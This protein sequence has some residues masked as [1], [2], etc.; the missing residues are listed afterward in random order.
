LNSHFVSIKVDREERPDVDRVYMA[1]VQVTTGSGG[2]P[3]SVWLTPELQPFYGGT[4]YPPHSQY[5]RPGFGDVLKE[6]ARAWRDERPQ[7]VESAQRLSARLH[8]MARPDAAIG[9]ASMPGAD[10]LT[11]TTRQF[12]SSF[13][14]RR[15]GFGDAP[16]FP[17]PSEL[18]F[19]LREHVRA[20]DDEA[21]EMALV[22]LRAMALGGMRDHIGGGFHRYSVD[23][24]WR[25]PHFEKMLYDQAQLVLAY[26]E[27]AQASQDPFFA[28]IAE[29]TLQYVSRDMTEQ[30]GGFFS[31]EDA[32][33]VP[34][35]HAADSQARKTEGAFYIWSLGEV[36]ALLG[37][38]SPTFELRYGLLPD[39]NAPFD[40]QQE[41]TGKNLLHTARGIAD[42][43]E[44]VKRQPEHVAEALTRARV[45][46]FKARER[47]PRPHLDDKVLTGWNGLMMAAF[48]RAAR[49]LS[50]SNLLGQALADDPGARHLA[51]ARRAALFL[52]DA[53]WDAGRQRLLRRYRRGDAAIDA[54]AEDYAFLIFGLLEL[55]QA[56]GDARWLEWAIALQRVQDELF[57]DREGGWYSTTGTD[58]SVL[59]RMKEEYD[60]AE[61]SASGVG[62][63]NLLTFAQLTG[64][65]SYSERAREV[66][67]AF[68]VRLQSL[69]RALP[70]MAA[71]L[72]AAHAS[73]EQIIVVG[74]A[75]A[76]ATQALWQAAN[77]KYRPFA[78]CVPV[79][80]GAGQRALAN[81]MPWIGSMSTADNQP[82][83]YVCRDFVCETPTSDPSSLL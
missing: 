11:A 42:I 3:M 72:S 2:W 35:E 83:A 33:S 68:A 50:G 55:F 47:R 45:T 5:G 77:T 20:G 54:Y 27:A 58:A 19:L 44:Q 10:A 26:L 4:Y 13:D 64:D 57:W 7:L 71:A 1:F 12:K 51:T 61:P 23:G 22:T 6:I 17:R 75:N 34:P 79:T 48:A 65:A 73:P 81:V 66:F 15:G 41:F 60:G 14:R 8:D 82:A 52:D 46:L 76:P 74:P 43:A 31:A 28:Q 40:P 29:D 78:T 38:D 9:Q 36:R 59:V 70:F 63:M 39:G 69:G 24:E 25:V 67:G 32:D 21:R 56:D 49:V 18:L 62:A 37:D 16:K 30:H 53:M 80:P